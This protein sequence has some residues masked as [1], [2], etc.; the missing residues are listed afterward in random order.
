MDLFWR[1]PIEN[2]DTNRWLSHQSINNI[3]RVSVRW[4]NIC[5]Q[6]RETIGTGTVAKAAISREAGN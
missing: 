4:M 2:S 5:W 3:S 1:Y 6:P